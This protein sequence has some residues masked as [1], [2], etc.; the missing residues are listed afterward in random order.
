MRAVGGSATT[1]DTNALYSLPARV[2]QGCNVLVGGFVFDLSC[3]DSEHRRHFSCRSHCSIQENDQ[4]L[5][6]VIAPLR[7]GAQLLSRRRCEE[8]KVKEMGF[9]PCGQQPRCVTAAA[10]RT[11]P[12]FCFRP[13]E[14]TLP[15]FFEEQPLVKIGHD[16]VAYSQQDRVSMIQLKNFL[17][18]D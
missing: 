8:R 16:K 3:T 15:M 1:R 12:L 6:S 18:A 11:I 7:S 13:E 14:R 5:Y 9:W 10:Y 2:A 4:R 17:A